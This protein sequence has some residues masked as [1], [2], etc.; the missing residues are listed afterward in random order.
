MCGSE[1]RQAVNKMSQLAEIHIWLVTFN[2]GA[3]Y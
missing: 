2:E 3:T 1:S